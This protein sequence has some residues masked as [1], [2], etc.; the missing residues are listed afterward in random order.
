ME[1][2]GKRVLVV[3]AGKSG[4]SAARF[5]LARGAEVT[6]TDSKDAK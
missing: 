2:A 4:L 6:L 5:L 3:G 1:L